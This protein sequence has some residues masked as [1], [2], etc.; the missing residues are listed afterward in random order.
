MMGC[1]SVLFAPAAEYPA[2]RA[3]PAAGMES[4]RAVA[5]AVLSVGAAPVSEGRKPGC[6]SGG[7]NPMNDVE[8]PGQQLI[9]HKGP[10]KDKGGALAQ[11]EKDANERLAQVRAAMKDLATYVAQFEATPWVLRLH[12]QRKVSLQLLWRERGGRRRH[13][14]WEQVEP[15]LAQLPV[16]LAQW[17]QEVQED[18]VILNHMEQAARYEHTTVQRV[19]NGRYRVAEM[20]EG[21][22]FTE[23][24]ALAESKT[25][26]S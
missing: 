11:W 24:L 3:A 20:Y 7:I 17:Y 9:H 16:G 26:F 13:C 25:K 22:Q 6:A 14:N 12:L 2:N 18:V 10:L 15:L 23:S 8:N 1:A 4:E 21:S 5:G 19:K